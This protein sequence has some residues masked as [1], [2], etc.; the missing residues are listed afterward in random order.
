[1]PS[2]DRLT[3]RIRAEFGELPGLK[4]TF[5][6]ACRLWHADE[7]KC[8]AALEAL[9]EEGFLRRSASGAFIALPKPGGKMMKAAAADTSSAVRC[10]HCHHLNVVSADR[11]VKPGRAF[12]PFRCVACWRIVTVAGKPA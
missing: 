2:L 5:A 9:V 10:P 12:A 7:T 1:M 8:L 11:A 3:D 4:V 6:Q